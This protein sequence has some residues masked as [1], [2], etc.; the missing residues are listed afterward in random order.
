[1]PIQNK[2]AAGW[3]SLIASAGAVLGGA[4]ANATDGDW[5]KKWSAITI[6]NGSAW[7]VS[8]SRHKAS[9]R[10]GAIRECRVRSAAAAED[11]GE[12]TATV[13]HGW[14]LA[15]ACGQRTF[16]VAEPTLEEAR[17]AARYREVEM[18]FAQTGGQHHG[19]HGKSMSPA[20]PERK[21]RPTY[22]SLTYSSRR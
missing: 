8:T 1:M 21:N 18:R 9:A 12:R 22:E 2:R 6:A 7:G 14:S 16:V 20:P 19:L 17:L 11:C 4:S 5:E 13:F 3:L 10:L 15:F